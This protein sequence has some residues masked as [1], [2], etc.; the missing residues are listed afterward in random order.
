MKNI[1]HLTVLI[2]LVFFTSIDSR[3]AKQSSS[4]SANTADISSSEIFDVEALDKIPRPKGILGMPVYPHE[5]KVRGEAG[6]VVIAVVVNTKG[7]VVDAQILEATHLEFAKAT[8]V[9]V[10]QW[11]FS[12]GK[13]KGKPVNFRMLA[14]PA[15]FNLPLYPTPEA[16]VIVD[17]E[18]LED[19]PKSKG[20][21]A[22]P[23]YPHEMKK[24]GIS[25]HAMIA[26][27]VDI[28]GNVVKTQVMEATNNEFAKAAMDA[29]S[30]WK[31]SPG[32]I[33]GKPVCCRM[34]SDPIYFNHISQ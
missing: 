21:K 17:A 2:A 22:K 19:R 13:I 14:E 25:G 24:L 6:H 5:M 3:A 4:S 31:F 18:H 7:K 23:Q 28:E 27:V 15:Y 30:Q 9:A 20:K 12:P 34:I 29:V 10:S 16:S 32:K 1:L 11:R 8:M 26:Y 33:N